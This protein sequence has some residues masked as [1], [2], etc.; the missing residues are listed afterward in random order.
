M[1]VDQEIK[2]DSIGGSRRQIFSKRIIGYFAFLF[3]IEWFLYFRHAAH[4]FQAD[5][6]ALL[7]YRGT[8]VFDVLHRFVSLHASGWYRPLANDIFTSALYPFLGLDPIGYRIPVYAF[9]IGSTI[10]AYALT[11]AISRNRIA[12]MIGT[13]FY[14]VH[15]TSG[16]VTFDLGLLPD[17]MSTFFY[18]LAVL[19]YLDYLRRGTKSAF[20]ISLACFV[21]SLL[22]KEAAVTMPGVLVVLYL[23]M[24]PHLESFR[25]RIVSAFKGCSAHILVLAVYLAFAVGYLNVQNV[26]Q[27]TT[28]ERP[29]QP[30]GY[31]LAFDETVPANADLAATWAMNIPRGYM[32]E[33]RQLTPGMLTFLKA[34]RAIFV[35]LLALL[36]IGRNRNKAL[37]G[38]AWFFLAL[39]PSLPLV[40]H[41][42]PNY[43]F[44]P[45]AGLSI[46]V[47]MAFAQ[48]YDIAG[49]FRPAAAISLVAIF[50]GL[51]YV[52]NH[53]IQNDIRKNRLLGGSA[54]LAFTSLSD[55]KRMYPTLPPDV[56]LFFEDSQEPLS[57]EYANG[58]LNMAYGTE[59]ISARFA[60]NGEA[61]GPDE[62][63]AQHT[64]LLRYQNKRL[65]DE[66]AALR[67]N[68]MA[69]VIRY[70]APRVNKLTLSRA[71]V[72]AGESYTLSVS[73]IQNAG[74]RIAYTIDDGPI[75]SF[76]AMLDAA[77]RAKFDVSASTKKGFYRFLGF[78]IAGRSEWISS[79]ATLTVR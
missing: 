43:L 36:L 60:S 15:T 40:D 18:L 2:A 61:L 63:A 56:T 42:L 22:S 33:W 28:L 26:L 45:L 62:S 35:A 39:I 4:F 64:I 20:R 14:S 32:G 65:V 54:E 19:A 6:I 47:G 27:F 79:D 7:Y 69:Y 5:S 53:G 8:S 34:F 29:E 76:T 23:A 51:L 12:A 17:L 59:D 66:T 74:L 41:L 49:R 68:P 11:F 24:N 67:A 55:L 44:L 31:H 73:G 10:A 25:T 16:F 38:I 50:A 72:V 3:V 1:T 30:D 77:G 57:W 70:Q 78:N 21:A 9:F 52:C 71:S 37:L 46:V 13:F 75:E 58:L 48:I